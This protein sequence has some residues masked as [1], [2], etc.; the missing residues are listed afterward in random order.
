MYRVGYLNANSLPDGKFAKAIGLLEKSFDFLFIAE[1]WYQ[2]QK[3]RLCHPLV[4]SSTLRP[5]SL[6]AQGRHHGGLYLLAT[7][8]ASTLIQSTTSTQHSI[9]V[10][11][12]GFTFAG[13]YYPPYSLSPVNIHDD[14][15]QI[16]CVDLLIGDINTRFTCNISTR[17]K[18][19]TTSQSQRSQLLQ[20]WAVRH[21]M[22]HLSDTTNHTTAD[23]IPDHSFSKINIQSSLILSLLPTYQ[24]QFPTDHK[25][26]LQISIKKSICNQNTK[27]GTIV[28]TQPPVRFRVQRLQQPSIATSFRQAWSILHQLYDSHKGSEKF[29]IDMLDSILCSTIQSISETELGLYQPNQVRKMDD[30]TAK[31]L[32]QQFDMTASIQ[33][34]KRAQRTV[35]ATMPI[36]SSSPNLTP[37]QECIRHYH[38]IFNKQ[39]QQDPGSTINDGHSK[40]YSCAINAEFQHHCSDNSHRKHEEQVLLSSG[41]TDM[42][43]PER[44][45]QKIQQMSSTSSSGSDGITVLML[46][47]LIP[48]SFP[49]VL[50]QLYNACLREA[51]IPSRW[52]QTLLYPICKDR[53]KPFMASNSRPIS[54]IC[55][56]RKIF[57]SLILPIVKGSGN[58]TNSPIQAGFRSGYSTLSNVLV[59]N[60]LIEKSSLSHLAFL[61]FQSAFDRVEGCYLKA[62]L[63]KQGMNPLVLKLVYQL[64][65]C[66]MGYALVVNRCQSQFCQRT[67]GL[68]Q[69]SPL[70]PILFNRFIDSLLQTL[71]RNTVPEVPTALF[72]ADD[73]VIITPTLVQTQLLL[74]LASEWSDNHGMSF[75]ILKCGH[76]ITGTSISNAPLTPL[77]LNRQAIPRVTAYK[78][79]GVIISVKGIDFS[80]QAD[81]LCSRIEK[82]INAMKWVSDTWAP[83]IRL[84]IFKAILSPTLEYS[85]PLLHAH[86]LRNSGDMSWKLVEKAYYSSMKRIA[87]GN[88][89]RPHLTCNLLGLLPFKDRSLHL[90]TRFYLHLIATHRDNP[91]RSILHHLNWF[92]K[93][94]KRIKLPRSG[95]L[96]LQFLNPPTTYHQFSPTSLN[97]SPI[98]SQQNIGV[99]LSDQKHNLIVNIRS[100]APN[101]IRITLL[102]DRIPG[103]DADVVLQS[104]TAYQAQFLAWRRGLFGWGRKCCCGERFDRGHTVCMPYPQ[105]LLTADQQELYNLDLYLL[106]T[107]I[108][109]TI[110]DFLLNQKF[111]EKAHKVLNYWSLTISRMLL[112]SST[113]L[114]TV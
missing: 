108:K 21:A 36:I 86:H 79:L 91:L 114:P 32:G 61:D 67:R 57:E 90:F 49:G 39:E 75:N 77:V 81:M 31:H 46:Q 99:S 72:F 5:T 97:L 28:N 113:A 42:I 19:L 68:P 60:H 52:N 110:M 95:P 8:S 50:S 14:L 85:L 10:S 18:Q 11:I 80:G 93:S 92:P 112:S 7:Q 100:K 6:S 16:D 43:S 12:P 37:L 38:H 111:W 102:T 89:N 33:L 22:I 88:A 44:I 69:G 105:P 101:L 107:N 51:K 3:S 104:P 70:A 103:I 48:T 4:H 15:K 96:L 106:D 56:F 59:L 34:L 66:D 24:L 78:Y 26:L 109:Y 13:V 54:L 83:R 76:L 64:M 29:D 45:T 23:N 2:H 47:H 20:S 55:L 73:G 35:T 74:D 82:Q 30:T 62:E 71:N 87:G 65:Y 27:S 9:K 25:Y 1:H 94:Y 98:I 63:T 17:R 53:N 58:M 40:P 84:N 41:L